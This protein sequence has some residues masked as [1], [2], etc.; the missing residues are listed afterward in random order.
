MT[1]KPGGGGESG[2]LESAKEYIISMGR[3]IKVRNMLMVDGYH[4]TDVLDRM[5]NLLRTRPHTPAPDDEQRTIIQIKRDIRRLAECDPAI[6]EYLTEQ[7]DKA[8]R[9]ATLATLDA[10]HGISDTP[11]EEFLEWLADRLVYVYKESPNVDF[12]LSLRK[13]AE[14]AESLR[15]AAQEDTR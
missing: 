7:W 14:Q 15:T 2:R 4:N 9:T 12:V 13:R 6:K 1:Y 10:M 3:I 11:I 5:V 8:A